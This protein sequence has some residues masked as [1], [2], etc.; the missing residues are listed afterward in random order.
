MIH[1]FFDNLLSVTAIACPFIAV[2]FLTAFLCRRRR[3]RHFN[4]LWSLACAGFMISLVNIFWNTVSFT[5]FIYGFE[6]H[7]ENINLIP[8]ISIVKMITFLMTDSHISF[9]II[10][11]FGNILFFLPVGFL[12]PFL[13][14]KF[15]RA[16]KTIFFGGLL[17]LL[18]EVWQLFLPRGTD[19]DDIILNTLG[20]ALGYCLFWI[21]TKLF[22]KFVARVRD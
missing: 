7:K 12:L 17:S 3:Q 15:E 20:T 8:I 13:S 1:F 4:W 18:I 6:L 21:I 5:P 22:P 2:A 10:N 11:L 19:I 14:Q 16:W 9:T